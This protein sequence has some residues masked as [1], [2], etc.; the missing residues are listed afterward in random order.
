MRLSAFGVHRNRNSR[1]PNEKA[2]VLGPGLWLTFQS[3]E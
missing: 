3:G 2:L 1:K